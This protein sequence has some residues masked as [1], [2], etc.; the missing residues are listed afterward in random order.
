LE[1]KKRC[2]IDPAQFS[3]CKGFAAMVMAMVGGV[4]GQDSIK[5]MSAFSPALQLPVRRSFQT[6][7]PA[8]SIVC[9]PKVPRRNHRP[10]R[11]RSRVGRQCSGKWPLMLTRRTSNLICYDDRRFVSAGNFAAVTSLSSPS[12][13][14]L[15][16]MPEG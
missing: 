13:L 9:H 8:I 16:I 11:R 3:V 1:R 14:S 15:Q 12:L 4:A 10:S 5:E 2:V 7:Q 6:A